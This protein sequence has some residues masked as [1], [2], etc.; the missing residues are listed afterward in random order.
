MSGPDEIKRL[1]ER[2]AK[3][4]ARRNHL[5][6]KHDTLVVECGELLNRIDTLEGLLREVLPLV[7]WCGNDEEAARIRAE[8]GNSDAT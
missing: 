1:Q 2:M 5:I 6:D 3:L 7:E 8:L 4:E